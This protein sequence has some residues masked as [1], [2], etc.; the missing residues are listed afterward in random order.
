MRKYIILLILLL[1][2]QLVTAASVQY[3]EIKL[4]V[5]NRPPIIKTI[6]ILPEEPYYDSVLECFIEIDDEN[7]ETL[8]Y[9]YEWYKNDLLIDEKSNKLANVDDN[10]VV[11]C[12][13]VVTDDFGESSEKKT[14]Q[15][16]ILESPVRV[17]L[18][19]PVLNMAGIDITA[20]EIKESTSMNA[21]TGMVT[22]NRETSPITLFFT[23]GI[24][25]F[26]LILINAIGLT[27]RYTRKIKSPK[28]GY[29]NA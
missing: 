21:V 17:R 15:T 12:L 4:Y 3:G 20:K 28:P 22:G 23:L 1:S 9:E 29:Q 5:Q 18:I 14:A 26:I 19:K 24:F 13:V 2:L 8:T 25:L 11:R 27:I 16:V 6:K 7:P 10:D